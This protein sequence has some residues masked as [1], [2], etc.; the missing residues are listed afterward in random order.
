MR[1]LV[2]IARSFRTDKCTN[3][4][5]GHCYCDY[6]TDAFSIYRDKPISLLEIGVQHGG[7]INVWD[8]Y[9]FNAK[10]IVGLDVRQLPKLTVN[11]R[12]KLI[13]ANA[14]KEETA[15]SL[16]QFDI[17]IDDGPH[18]LASQLAAIRLYLPKVTNGGL[19]IIEDVQ[20]PSWFPQ[21]RDEVPTRLREAIK[22][23]D[24]RSKNKRP[25]DLLFTVNM[26]GA[27]LWL[28]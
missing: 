2:E 26:R 24:F 14:Y 7:S 6:Y 12:V 3:T 18:T 16:G 11:D 10:L 22:E 17:I 25:D 19:F 8:E 27:S 1:T 9:F 13:Q 5:L 28:P 21:L 15:N 4:R 23:F 20:N